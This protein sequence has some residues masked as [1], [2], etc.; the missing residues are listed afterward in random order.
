MFWRTFFAICFCCLALPGSA[1][2]AD[3]QHLKQ[4]PD[5]L[6]KA[7]FAG[8]CFW[9]MQHP[10]DVLDGVV[11]TTVGYTGG[12]LRNPS[13][14]QV[15]AG[16]TGHAEAIEV[17]FDSSRISYEK[18]LD[19][20][21]RQIDPT[22]AGGQFVDRGNQY[23]SAIFYHDEIQKKK[24]E[25]SKAALE[26]SGRFGAPL[27]TG[28]VPASVF[29]RAEEYHQKYYEKNPFRYKFYRYGSGRDKYLQK[30]WGGEGG[31]KQE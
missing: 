10:F 3:G 22:D 18:L 26:K 1:P 7:T 8:G 2:A 5:M 13:Y 6:E 27:V 19:V 20:F 17:V 11:S 29:Y 21:W 9:C 23:R 4:E 15:S 25:A 16:G 14:A 24:A 28:V 31:R 30:I 12:Q